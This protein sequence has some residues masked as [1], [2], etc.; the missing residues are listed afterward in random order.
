V[1]QMRKVLSYGDVLLAPRY[2]KCK[3]KSDAN[4]GYQYDA[5]IEFC[6]VPLINAPMDTAG[7]SGLVDYLYH[8]CDMP[9]TVHRFFPNVSEQ[10]HFLEETFDPVELVH[11]SKIFVAVGSVYKWKDW[12]DSLLEYR[13]SKD[14]NFG[15]LVDMAN[16]DTAACVDTVKYLTDVKCFTGNLMAGNVATKSGLE[17]LWEAGANFIRVGIGSGSICSTRINT[18]FGIPVFSSLLDCASIKPDAC[19]IVACGGCEE[20]GDIL[21]AIA[22]GADMVMC[23]KLFAAT[24]LA[25]GATYTKDLKETLKEDEKYYKAYHGMASAKAQELIGSEE[26]K[27]SIEGVSGLVRY[28]GRTEDVVQGI[29]QNLRSAMTYYAGVTNWNEFQRKTKFLEITPA[30]RKE[31]ETRVFD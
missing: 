25:G 13:E 21:K 30:G 6:A 15:I 4:L 8:K 5:N 9:A 26:H 31:S 18:G 20:P 16:G 27:A 14:L 22:A 17:R 23:G 11:G 12:I 3:H 10:I 7:H 29:L 19:Y 2:S 1:S 24:S 28:S